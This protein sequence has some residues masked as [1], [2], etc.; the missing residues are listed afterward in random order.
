MLMDS[1]H[2]GDTISR[3]C[4]YEEWEKVAR[5]VQE[6]VDERQV[7]EFVSDAAARVEALIDEL[8]RWACT[9]EDTDWV[10]EHGRRSRTEWVA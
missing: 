6:A 5:R 8:K 4:S 9:P 10:R 3:M 7:G 2:R 1:I